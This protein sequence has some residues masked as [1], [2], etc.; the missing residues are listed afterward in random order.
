MWEKCEPMELMLLAINCGVPRIIGWRNG[1]PVRSAIKKTPVEAET[2]FFGNQGT[3]GDRQ[4]NRMVHG[5]P[6][7]AVCAYSADHWA[8]WR[9]EMNLACEPGTFGENLTLLGAD[10]Q[11]VGIGDRFAWGEVVLEVTQPRGPCA[12]VDLRHRRTNL[13]QMMTLSGRC[14]WYMRVV[15]EGSAST[16][17]AMIRHIAAPDRPSISD[18]F[19]ARY[20]SR[21]TAGLRQRVHDS[22]PLA[23][24]WR[25]AIARTFA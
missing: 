9:N 3:L 1:R 2:I 21:A 6:D 25:R 17:N 14:G 10:E 7:K 4:A 11:T 16:R 22:A 18:A 20:D 15:R 8:W 23:P 24:A 19:A 12:N 5:G 13:A